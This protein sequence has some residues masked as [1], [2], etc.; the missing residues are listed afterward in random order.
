MPLPRISRGRAIAYA[1]I[2]IGFV[3]MV[4]RFALGLGAVTNLNDGRPWGLWIAF[5]VMTGVALAAGGF[6]L[7]A[8]VYVF[9]LK[10]FHALVR[11][12]KLSAFIGYAL[13]VV[14]ILVDLGLPWRIWHALV[15]WNTS[16]VLFEVAW[17]VMLYTTVLAVDVLAMA[18][19]ALKMERAVRFFRSIY[20]FLVVAGI[21]LSTLHQSSLG[22]LFLVVPE[23]MSELWASPALGP[24]FYASAIVAGLS[25]V[26]LENILGAR[27]HGRAVD[28]PLVSSLGKGLATA[29]LVYFAM[30]VTDLYARN[31]TVWQ[32]DG[33]HVAF[34]VEL[35]GT[36]ALPA[37]LLGLFPSVRR[38]QAGLLA[39]AGLSAFGVVLNRF[40]VALTAQFGFRDF[41]YFPSI[42]EI[43]VTVGLVA[44]AIVAFDIGSRLLPVYEHAEAGGHAKG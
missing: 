35:F 40:N 26:T 12:A 7:S 24:M 15:M 31:V 16:S 23:K 9:D 20:I 18:L 1:L 36:V 19:E 42:F 6:T 13:V 33:R 21:V 14:G 39:C 5:D 3:S 25:V 27:A 22:A 29:L 30:K 10:K 28:M 44:V 32:L 11:P 8:A 4:L 34:W 37:A 41:T 38:T 17:C 43:A 2:L